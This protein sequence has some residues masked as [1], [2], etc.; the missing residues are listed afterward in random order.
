MLTRNVGF[1]PNYKDLQPRKLYSSHSLPCSRNTAPSHYP[2]PAQLS[3]HTSLTSIS[4]LSF[5]ICLGL[6]SYFFPLCSSYHKAANGLRSGIWFHILE[7]RRRCLENTWEPVTPHIHNIWKIA[8]SSAASIHDDDLTRVAGF[9]VALR[10]Y[11]RML[12]QWIHVHIRTVN[13]P[14]LVKSRL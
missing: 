13:S 9:I 14:L 10:I 3:Y 8:A 11:R 1:S 12:Q 6:A 7:Q 2:K 5:H 4:I